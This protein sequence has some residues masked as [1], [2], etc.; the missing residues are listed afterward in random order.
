MNKQS[1]NN[2]TAWEYRA[3][4]FW[5]QS[6]GTPTE[7]AKKISENPMD[8]LKLHKKYFDNAA[9]LKIAVPC[10]SCGKRA[11][12]L[13]LMG[14]EVTVFDISEE[15]KRYA[16]EIAACAGTY[17][18]YVLGDLYDIDITKYSG[19]FDMLYM[20]GGILHY[21][22]DINRL[23]GIF[24]T[25]LK[26]GGT[27]VLSDFHPLRKF[28]GNGNYSS[29]LNP[30]VDESAGYNYFDTGLHFGDVAYKG[31]FEKEEQKG[32]PD[33]LL[34]VFTLSEIINSV[35]DAG[36]RLLKFDEHPDWIN[37]NIPGEYTIVAKKDNMNKFGIDI[38]IL[39]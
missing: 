21:F 17:V 22:N 24:Q 10:G 3:Y 37:A 34:R 16:L 12:A 7:L 8:R 32:F 28:A 15:N 2:K 30:R 29:G 14:A 25:I 6:N 18:D 27:M 26:T 4:E 11:V 13:A 31:F 38:R 1:Q 20:E 39:L 36:L 23:M 19:Y 33:V 5:V 9:G 35:I